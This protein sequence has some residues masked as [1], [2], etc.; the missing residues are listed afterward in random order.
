MDIKNLETAYNHATRPHD[1]RD[2]E[3]MSTSDEILDSVAH[4]CG[5]LSENVELAEHHGLKLGKDRPTTNAIRALRMRVNRM[6]D[7][8]PDRAQRIRAELGNDFPQLFG[9]YR[10]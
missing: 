2:L 7:L 3:R 4:W 10:D 5:V 6:Q 8:D 1:V 9:E